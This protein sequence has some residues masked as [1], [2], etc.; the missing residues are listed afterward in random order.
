MF[1]KVRVCNQPIGNR[2]LNILILKPY[3]FVGS[4]GMNDDDEANTVKHL[5]ALI[6][7]A[8]LTASCMP[9][10]RASECTR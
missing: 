2:F 6:H 5:S 7:L 8:R 1:C 4:Q 3:F 9:I 10:L